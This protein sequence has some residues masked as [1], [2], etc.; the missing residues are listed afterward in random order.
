MKCFVTEVFG[1]W[2]ILPLVF[3]WL[4][5]KI[6]LKAFKKN[7]P[8]L[9]MNVVVVA[10]FI[11]DFFKILNRYKDVMIKIFCCKFSLVYLCLKYSGKWKHWVLS[12]WKLGQFVTLKFLLSYCFMQ[13]NPI[14]NKMKMHLKKKKNLSSCQH[15]SVVKF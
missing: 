4:L 3:Y 13:F 9:F 1:D 12:L 6:K 11:K 10:Y 7:L 2:K 5:A 8:S 14:L 15:E